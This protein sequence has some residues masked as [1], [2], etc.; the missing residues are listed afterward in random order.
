[1]FWCCD[2]YYEGHVT[3][4]RMA[5]NVASFFDEVTDALLKRGAKH[6]IAA[7]CVLKGIHNRCLEHHLC[8]PVCLKLQNDP[9]Y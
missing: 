3:Y 1:M 9:W 7:V 5:Q 2:V 6:D 8:G 4:G